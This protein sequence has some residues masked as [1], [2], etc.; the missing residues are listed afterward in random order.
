MSFDK[1]GYE[2]LPGFLSSDECRLIIKHAKQHKVAETGW[3]KARAIHDGFYAELAKDKKYLQ[4]LK[5][6][7]GENILHWGTDFIVRAPGAIHAWHTDIESSAS[8]GGFVSVWIGLQNTSKSASLSLVSRSHRFGITI[9]EAIQY[10]GWTRDNLRSRDVESLAKVFDSSAK[11]VNCKV[12]NGDAIV[13]DGRLWH[14]SHNRRWF[15]ARLSLLLQYSRAVCPIRMYDRN[16]LDWP[17]KYIDHEWPPVLV[18]TGKGIAG[19]NNIY[20]R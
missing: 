15:G 14:G 16:I 9:Q 1:E 8:Q 12:K 5:P 6:K 13:F 18:L 2:I 19:I 10:M 7:L 20:Y 17:F 3:G 11:V 4:L